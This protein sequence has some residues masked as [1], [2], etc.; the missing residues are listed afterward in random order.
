[1]KKIIFI[2]LTFCFFQSGFAQNDTS[3]TI[4][5]DRLKGFELYAR[6]SY[7]YDNYFAFGYGMGA[8]IVF[9]SQKPFNFVINV[10]DINNLDFRYDSKIYNIGVF[11]FLSPSI[12]YNIG[13]KTKL[14]FELGV[15]YEIPFSN[16]MILDNHLFIKSGV[17]VMFPIGERKIYLKSYL[18]W[19][20]DSSMIVYFPSNNLS[21][22]FA[23]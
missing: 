4:K 15:S 16:R 11:T 18:N 2:L 12:R 22:G 6:G 7:T 10:I 5:I 9:F 23:F 13:K 20:F 19:A 14:F 17:G 8:N 3:S 21:L 1:M